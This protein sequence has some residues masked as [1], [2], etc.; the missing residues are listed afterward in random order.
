MCDVDE[1][2]QSQFNVRLSD[3]REFGPA[4]LQTIAQW[5]REGRIPLD[6]L[7]APVEHGQGDIRSVLAEPVLRD[8]LQ[9]PPTVF[10]GLQQQ[11]ADTAPM[12]GMIPY[13]NPPAL[14]GY[15]VSI[16]ALLP[17]VG[18]L[19]GIPA[20]ILGII[21][22]RKRLKD[23]KVRGL[24][25]AWIAIILGGLCTIGYSGLILLAIAS[26]RM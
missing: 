6:A 5:A 11:A 15:Y 8:I 9:A 18:V 3:G 16:F 12:S 24:A 17:F 2:A 13:K 20:V 26:A 22:L 7:L 4:P 21:G 10:T 1:P 14:I 25:H 19:F 23:P